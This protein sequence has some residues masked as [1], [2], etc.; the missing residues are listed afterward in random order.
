MRLIWRFLLFQDGIDS[1]SIL[2]LDLLHKVKMLLGRVW[3]QVFHKGQDLVGTYYS[4]MPLNRLSLV[5]GR[6]IKLV[7]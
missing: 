3:S 6:G 7:V 4:R 2:G 5:E 1:I